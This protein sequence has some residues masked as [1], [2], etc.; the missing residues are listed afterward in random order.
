MTVT[1]H[2]SSV[3]IFILIVVLAFIAGFTLRDNITPFTG[4]L[5]IDTSDPEKDK[6]L[7]RLGEPTEWAA[8]RHIVKLKVVHRKIE[9][10]EK[11]PEEK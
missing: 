1:I 7:I 11:W 5:V 6:W 9:E 4:E 3:A 2:A 10:E 8:K